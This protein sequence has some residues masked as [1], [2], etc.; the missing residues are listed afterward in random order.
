MKRLDVATAFIIKDGQYLLQ[1]RRQDVYRGAAGLIGSFG[2]K[3]H[4]GETPI[5]AL[6]RELSEETSL[7]LPEE[8]YQE[9]GLVKVVSDHELELVEV[10]LTAFGIALSSDEIFE[11]NEGEIV[12]LTREEALARD[13][14]TSGTK[15]C[16]LELI[17]E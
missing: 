13:D 5:Q 11:T 7:Q 16:F 17:K 2:G 4:A 3:L 9:I 1:R 12:L 10:H 8:R 15:A 6:L 14:L